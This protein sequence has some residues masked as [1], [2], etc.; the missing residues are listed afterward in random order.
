MSKVFYI[1]TELAEG[2]AGPRGVEVV[3]VL[4]AQV[5]DI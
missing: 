4:F 2:R 1:F 5:W 3:K